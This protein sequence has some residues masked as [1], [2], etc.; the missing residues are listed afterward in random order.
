MIYA[1]IDT[2][3]LVSAQ[4]S[5]QPHSATVKVVSSMFNGHIKP[6]YNDE[7]L[8]EYTEVFHRPKFHL[9][10]DD[11]SFMLDYIRHYGIHSDRIPFAGDMPDEKDRPFYEVSLSMDDSFLVTGNLKHFPATPK[12]ISPADMVAII[13]HDILES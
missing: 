11:I 2:N 8:A 10:D 5:K 4:I 3:V 1:V 12:V 7:I 6:V 9:S 13:E